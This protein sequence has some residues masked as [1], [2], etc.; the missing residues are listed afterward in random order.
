MNN[1]DIYVINLDKDTDRL[2]QIT[3]TLS[4]NMFTRIPGVYGNDLNTEEYDEILYTSKHFVP[5][6]AIGCAMS[7]R[8]AIQT[9]MNTSNKPYAL[10]LEDDAVPLT[11]HYMEEVADAI[12]NAPPDW[13]IIKLDYNPRYNIPYYHRLF[14]LQTTAYIINKQGAEKFLRQPIIYHIDVDMNFYDLKMYNNPKVL[15]DQIWDKN[16]HSNNRIYSLYNPLNYIHEGINFKVLRIL[17]GEY[18]VADLVLYLLILT[19]IIV[20]WVHRVDKYIVKLL[21]LPK[22]TVK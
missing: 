4:P 12:K 19:L 17:G 3:H 21:R 18:T 15:F 7:H 11:K 20:L 1:F 14:T 9:F 10:I 22:F 8:K 6:S 16:N 2:H 13:N 5:K